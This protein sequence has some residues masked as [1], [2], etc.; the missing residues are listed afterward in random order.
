M[1]SSTQCPVACDNNNPVPKSAILKGIDIDKP[2]GVVYKD[3][4]KFITIDDESRD[5]KANGSLNCCKG[6][7][8]QTGWEMVR[9]HL[10]ITQNLALVDKRY[11]RRNP[12]QCRR[13]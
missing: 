2:T 3:G 9:L 6:K 13:Q 5:S 12:K 11:L 1:A 7:A 10:R 8:S 4:Q